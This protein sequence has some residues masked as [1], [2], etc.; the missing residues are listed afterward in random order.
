MN[1]RLFKYD[2]KI[3]FENYGIIILRIIQK[4]IVLH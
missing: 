3:I 4:I 1:V 2:T